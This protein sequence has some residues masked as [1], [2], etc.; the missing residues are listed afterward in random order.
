MWL[1]VDTPPTSAANTPTSEE[2]PSISI[3]SSSST[4]SSPYQATVEDDTSSDA[5]M[6]GSMSSHN[7]SSN[8]RYSTP[9]SSVSDLNSSKSSKSSRPE[10]IL[11]KPKRSGSSS[12]SPRHSPGPRPTVHFSDRPAVHLHSRSE[13][14]QR[15][16]SPPTTSPTR[17]AQPDVSKQDFSLSAVDKKWGQLF[18]E[19]DEPTA[20]LGQFLRGIAN[21]MVS[22]SSGPTLISCNVKGITY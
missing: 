2:L 21:F 13:P 3:G 14:V 6:A 8:T 9:T 10:S 12:N 1:A 20:R 16:Q 7:S 5:D 15:R 11:V 18:T 22:F 19:A 17:A 4:R